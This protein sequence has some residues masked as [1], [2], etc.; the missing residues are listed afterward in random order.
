MADG[1]PGDGD[2]DPRQVLAARADPEEAGEEEAG[3]E[4][5]GR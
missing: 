2:G 3:E 4:Q 5:A 1:D